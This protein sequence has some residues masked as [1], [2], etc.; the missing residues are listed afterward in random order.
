MCVTL[1]RKFAQH[2]ETALMHLKSWSPDATLPK[3]A[4][5]GLGFRVQ[6]SWV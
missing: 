6:G 5:M 2:E 4:L 1:R 3:L